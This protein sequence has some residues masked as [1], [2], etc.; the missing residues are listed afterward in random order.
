MSQAFTIEN[1]NVVPDVQPAPDN[2]RL[3]E[4]RARRKELYAALFEHG[5]WKRST[6]KDAGDDADLGLADSDD[7]SDDD[8]PIQ[9]QTQAVL[10]MSRDQAVPKETISQIKTDQT[11]EAWNRVDSDMTQKPRDV[12]VEASRHKVFLT[13][14][15]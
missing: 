7:E 4:L 15:L 12:K 14:D 1:G 8:K 5:G 6:V 13:P 10:L 9:P 11:R 2:G 3:A